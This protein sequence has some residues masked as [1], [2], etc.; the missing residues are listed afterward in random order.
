[1]NFSAN[2]ARYGDPIFRKYQ[3]ALIYCM[4]ITLLVSFVI[5]LSLQMVYSSS[6][7]GQAMENIN[8]SIKLENEDLIGAIKK[9][10]QLT[11]F[12]FLYRTADV[13]S[14]DNLNINA[15]SIS[16][17]HLMEQLLAG[18]S[19]SFKQIDDRIL[20]TRYVSGK[21]PSLI[22]RENNASYALI[23]GTVFDAKTKD[24]L[25]GV[26][27]RI[28]NGSA[29]ALTDARGNFRI[30]AEMGDILLIS[31]IGYETQEVT[32]TK[33]VL[34]IR[35]EE[36]A[37]SLKGVVV[38]GIFSQ[39][40]TTFTGA[41]RTFN[42]QELSK[43]SNNNVL[44]ALKSL[45][46]SF[47]MPENLN[48]GSNP[49]VLPD[50]VLRGGNTLLDISTPGN[51]NPFNYQSAP[52]AP[53]FILDG[54]ET[55]LQRVNDLDM[56]RIASVTILKD[57]GATAIYGS[58]GANGVIVIEQNRPV[59]GKLRVSYN[60]S[61]TIEAPD[62]TG[63]NLLDAQ[64][65]FDLEDR[66]NAFIDSWNFKQDQLDLYRESRLRAVKEG[67]NTDW[68]S[69]PL[70]TGVGQK[71]N[72]YVE[73]GADAVSYGLSLTYDR[74]VGVMKSSDRTTT[75]ANSFLSYR[76]K[77][78]QFRNDLTLNFNKANNS[79]YGSFRQYTQLNPYW[80]PYNADGTLKVYLETIID[81][82]TGIRLTNFDNYNNLNG[83]IGRPLNPLYNASLNIK[84]QTS[85]RG[86]TNNF[87]TRW[88]AKEWL[89]LTGRLS[90][91]TQ[92]D[93]S[94]IFLPAQHSSFAE[95]PTFEKG[96][97]TKGLGKNQRIEGFLTAEA[98]KNFDKHFLSAS[99]TLNVKENT[100]DTQFI[101]VE[102]FPNPTLDELI[103][104]NQYPS[105]GKPTGTEGISRSIGTLARVAYSYDNRY[106]FDATFRLDGSSLFG[107]D[108]RYAPFWS[109]GAGWNIKNESFLKDND[110]VNE[111][112]LR[113]TV[114]T[115]GSESFE[116]FKGV[117]TSQYYTDRE[118][119][120]IIA[121][122]LL[123]YGNS[124]LAWQ[125]TFKQNIGL[126]LTLFRNRLSLNANY[127]IEQTKGS[128]AFISSAPSSGFY[129]Y[130][131]N[132]GDVV[133]KGYELYGRFNIIANP[134][135]RNNWSV[136]ANAFHFK[137]TIEK[138]SKTIEALN[139]RSNTVSST[140]PLP[141]YAEGQ[142]KNAI[143]AVKSLGID[144][145][146]GN[147]LFQT[148]NG[149]VTTI[150]NPADQ[151]IVGDETPTLQG[152]F[153][154]NMEINGIGFN[155]YLRFNFGGD[156]YNQTLI[157]R[158]ENVNVN[159]YN[160]DSRVAS[161]RWQKPGD[162]AFFK[163]I[164]DY[165]GT[166]LNQARTYAS[167]RFV[168]KNNFLAGESASVY[169]RFADKLNKK[170]GLQNTK[171]TLFTNDLFRL[172]SIKRERGLD[173]PFSHSF[174]LQLQTTF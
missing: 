141:R 31:Y 89:R 25:V 162:V 134:A 174:T 29:R 36:S 123:G 71:H 124:A 54:F 168:Q 23:T 111:F 145:A 46:P 64:G 49:N 79:P 171:V 149:D 12:R 47:Q 102:G 22:V 138:V 92:N 110:Q 4:R 135:N 136:F 167:S 78:F 7:K 6:A 73:G 16:V 68:M 109:L 53:L 129:G 132:M 82:Q 103:L 85:F 27:V 51:S 117:T 163:G 131:D 99:A 74:N 106:L 91:T 96:S 1:M 114:G 80:S 21:V 155:V 55:T 125:K 126:D 173:Y 24:R 157:D 147:E 120:G 97:Y 44:S 35:L 98:N 3:H 153:G 133:N 59:D 33:P 66:S 158:V 43:V 164:L 30:S 139:N 45:D 26:T 119:R 10:E 57:A 127:F 100:F 105:G 60:A 39:S 48:I 95:K 128:I 14:I 156:S 112:R 2:A 58:R 143:W 87:E 15:R 104:G 63:Y 69:K 61:M 150:Y 169:Y 170:L 70:R 28:K 17:A 137:N 56:N 8:V 113:Y 50:V 77:N 90:Y 159:Y 84:D 11:P 88:Q 41:A 5:L 65:K 115:T 148:L 52:N 121:T 140:T 161:D 37:Q 172:G 116:S 160:V 144:P 86:I 18:T 75:T 142:S 151:M 40:K 20:I 108:Q 152:T 118:Y 83:Y 101:R 81:P 122:Y 72:V 42:A 154:T 9:I 93:E 76:I 19:L 107:S 67:V 38:T 62:L 166:P 130:Y 146:S 32:V 13:K 165:T 34:E 94:D